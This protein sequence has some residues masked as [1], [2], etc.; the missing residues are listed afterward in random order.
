MDKTSATSG[1]TES[2]IE[3]ELLQAA[4]LHSE[5]WGNSDFARILGAGLFVAV[6]VLSVALLIIV[7]R[8]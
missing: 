7:I 5:Y 8:G 6:V 2:R 4:P 1:A 3:G